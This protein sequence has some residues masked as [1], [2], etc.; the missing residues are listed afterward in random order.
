[1]QRAAET[2]GS[3]LMVE[4]IGFRSRALMGDVAPSLHRGINRFDARETAFDESAR[5]QRP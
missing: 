3:G 1:M 2:T 4:Q 5:G